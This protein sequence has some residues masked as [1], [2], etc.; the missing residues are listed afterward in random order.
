MHVAVI[1]LT[2]ISAFEHSDMGLISELWYVFL[3]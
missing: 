1:D 2:D 3:T